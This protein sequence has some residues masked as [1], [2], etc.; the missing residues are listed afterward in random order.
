MTHSESFKTQN[1]MFITFETKFHNLRTFFEA[2]LVKSHHIGKKFA[3]PRLIKDVV[4]CKDIIPYDEISG[5]LLV[6]TVV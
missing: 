3:M 2:V 1:S 6:Y 4:S 5:K